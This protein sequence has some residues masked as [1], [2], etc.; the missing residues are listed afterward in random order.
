VTNDNNGDERSGVSNLTLGL[1][2]ALFAL[3]WFLTAIFW[4]YYSSYGTING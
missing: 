3:L 4:L 1:L 2:L